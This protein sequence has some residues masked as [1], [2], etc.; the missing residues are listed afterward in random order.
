MCGIAGILSRNPERGL[1]LRSVIPVLRHRGPDDNGT[2]N[3]D[4]AHFVHTR[5]SIL[6]LNPSGHQPMSY[7]DNRYWIVFNG[8][9]YNYIE[10]RTELKKLGYLFR[11]SGD[12]EVLMASY[13]QWGKECVHKFRGM[14]AFALWDTRNK[15][16]FLARDRCGERPLYYMADEKR[17]YFA[18]EMKALLKIFPGSPELLPKTL[19]M[20]LHYQYIPEPLTA[21]RGIVKLPAAHFMEIRL[22]RWQ[23]SPVRYWD[24]DKIA[25]ISGEPKAR[26]RQEL[27]TAISLTLRSDVPIGI[28]LSGGIDSS[29]LTALSA[30]Q[31]GSNLK[32]FSVGYPG[33]PRFDERDQARSL[34]R[35]LGIEFVDTEL[36][37]GEAVDFFPSMTRIM[38][39][40]IGD[41]AAFGH[42][43]VMKLAADNGV[44]VMLSGLGGD[45]LF[46]GYSWIKNAVMLSKTK[47]D[48]TSRIPKGVLSLL[49]FL[50][51]IPNSKRVRESRKIPRVIRDFLTFAY[52]VRFMEFDHPEQFVYQN[53]VPLFLDAERNAGTILSPSYTAQIDKR[54]SFAPFSGLDMA[55]M[56]T[57]D[58]SVCRILFETWLVSNCL[59][60]GDRV[61]MASSVETRLPL[62]D[63][64]LIEV[65]FG[66]RQTIKDYRDS[67]KSWLISA[68]TDLVPENV[69]QRPKQGFRPPNGWVEGVLKKYGESII[70]G[71]LVGKG[72]V[73]KKGIEQVVSRY[74]QGKSSNEL[75]YLLV[76]FE[77]W[78][79]VIVPSSGKSL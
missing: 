51:L 68:V 14:F 40:P 27:E 74:N 79:N 78:L 25:P 47:M 20:F 19:D 2:W 54:N 72:A 48:L 52:H 75:F 15:T 38:D 12:T 22:D 9:I 56:E 3:D 4:H 59:A 16:L 58:L 8:E 32:A 11:S 61:S 10:L 77:Q 36:L 44:K 26:I 33:N 45:E 31:Y 30:K 65:V 42:Y 71:A 21:F 46:W 6:D 41:V 29:A 28:A 18:S 55:S 60:L 63:S 62:L 13:A 64:K 76:L 66:L 43:S 37:D 49:S 34:A 39:D 7:G 67:P 70:D 69:L 23:I 50:A 1:D 53:Q 35:T 57:A 24:I 5:L 73:T 17:V